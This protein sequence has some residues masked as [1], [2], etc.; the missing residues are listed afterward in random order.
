MEQVWGSAVDEGRKHVRAEDY[1]RKKE[2]YPRK[3]LA[4]DHNQLRTGLGSCRSKADD[5][6][7]R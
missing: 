2:I 6:V 5:C 1:K 4:T 7:S 3:H